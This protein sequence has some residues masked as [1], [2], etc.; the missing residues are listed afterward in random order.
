MFIEKAVQQLQAEG[1]SIDFDLVENVTH[2]ELKERYK[3]CHLFID[4]ILGGWYGTASIEA[5]AL[6]RPVM[7]FIREDYLPYIDYGDKVP[8]YSAD[9]DTI[10]DVLKSVLT[11]GYAELENR[12]HMS[13][14]F[15]EEVHDVTVLTRQLI[16][17]YQSL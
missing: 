12:S 6:G 13:R 15:I 3:K 5:M 8:V 16:Q 4:Q 9:P 17:L 1:F 11:A 2:A 7:A 10:Y 14:R